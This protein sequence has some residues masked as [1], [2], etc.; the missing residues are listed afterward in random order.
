MTRRFPTLRIGYL[1]GGVAWACSLFADLVGH[2]EKRNASRIGDL[3]PD[4]LDVDQLVGYFSEYGDE[5]VTDNLDRLRDY[6]SR[7]GAR[8]AQVD[9][10]AACE[11]GRPDDLRALFADRFYFGCEADD[12]LLTWAFRE[13]VNP[14]GARL[15]PVFGS[16]IAHWDVPDM[17][18]PVAEA[19]ELVERGLIGSASSAS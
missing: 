15:R 17:T 19:H 11:I 14:F 18:E 5:T 12:P 13:D 10:F 2:W 8:P 3:D 16:D 7:P 1:E 6:F 9:E 4:N